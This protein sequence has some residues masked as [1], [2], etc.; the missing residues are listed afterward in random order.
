VGE[1]IVYTADPHIDP[2]AEPIPLITRA[3]ISE[4]LEQVDLS[5]AVDVTGGMRSKIEGM[6]QLVEALPTLEIHLITAAAGLLERAL[7][8]QANNEGT[9]IRMNESG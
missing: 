2:M 8:G 9:H 5:D 4:V 6:W 1:T 7:L 3:N